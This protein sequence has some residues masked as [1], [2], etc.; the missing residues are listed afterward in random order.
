MNQG[1][2][3]LLLDDDA[4][5]CDAMTAYLEAQGCIVVAIQ[6]PDGLEAAIVKHSPD[7]LLLDQRLGETTGTQLLREMRTRSNLP[8]IIVTG[9][10]DPVDRILNL[11]LGADDEIDKAITPRELLARIRAVLR[12]ERRAPIERAQD[13]PGSGWQFL[14]SKREL[15]RPDGSECHLTTAEF[16]TLRL[17][18]ESQ[19][20]AVSRALLCRRVFGRPFQPSDRGVDTV[21]KKLRLKIDP[22][23]MT[24]CIR[25]VRPTGYV[26]TNFPQTGGEEVSTSL[27]A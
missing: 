12:R 19:G 2:R 16:E 4:A 17:L 7:I 15:R 6:R 27:Q 1:P 21:I 8:C 9:A 3:I 18:V 23:G 26:F 14:V 10:S 20:V 24:T 11:E 22:P 25:S 13:A 5:F